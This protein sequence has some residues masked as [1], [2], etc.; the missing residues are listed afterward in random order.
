MTLDEFR[1]RRAEQKREAILSAAA[2]RFIDNGYDA[3]TIEAIARDAE[4]STAT[5]YS[6]FGSKAELFAAVI[7]RAAE[8]MRIKPFPDLQSAA[9]T[10][11][12]LVASPQLR[13][14][15]RLI[16]AESG[17]FPELGEALFERGKAAVY[18]AFSHAF[19][20]EARA[21]RIAPQEDWTLAASQITGMIGQS[22]LM[23]W[24]I[25]A[26]DPVRDRYEVADAAA[27]IFLKE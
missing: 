19:E 14:L 17:R 20:A 22:V 3:A 1:S 8:V 16:I 6:Y 23:P 21:G 27:A 5:V 2:T 11:S 12:D 26:R 25:T 7:E 24:L 13:G 15:M 18:E 4:V 10:Y 9:R